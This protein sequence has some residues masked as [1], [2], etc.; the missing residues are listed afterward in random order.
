[1]PVGLK[2]ILK[3]QLSGGS[4]NVCPAPG[5][6]CRVRAVQVV[7]RILN[8]AALTPVTDDVPSE[9]GPKFAGEP[10]RSAKAMANALVLELPTFTAPKS[11]AGMFRLGRQ[12]CTNESSAENVPSD[13]PKLLSPGTRSSASESNAISD[14]VSSIDGL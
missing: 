1:M 13:S 8:S 6:S 10:P 3:L 14:P 7:L 5:P 9:M 2:R 4:I 12:V 11:I